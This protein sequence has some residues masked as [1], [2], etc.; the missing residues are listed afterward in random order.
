MS[1]AQNQ[2]YIRNNITHGK[3][4]IKKEEFLLYDSLV[5]Y[6]QA[7]NANEKKIN[8]LLADKRKINKNVSF[9]LDPLMQLLLKVSDC[10]KNS[11]V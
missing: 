1:K 2:L 5:Y 8:I 4:L 11:L 9:L 10:R 6:L 7:T 3:K